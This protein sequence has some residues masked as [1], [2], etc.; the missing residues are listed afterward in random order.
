MILARK[1]PVRLAEVFDILNPTALGTGQN[2]Q[3]V[4]KTVEL[5][6]REVRAS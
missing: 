5:H 2:L 1:L 3:L 4:Q 6:F